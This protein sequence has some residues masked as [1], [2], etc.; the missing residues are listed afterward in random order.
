MKTMEAKMVK[1]LAHKGDP[2]VY[3][4]TPHNAVSVGMCPAFTGEIR[5]PQT[6]EYFVGNDG[7]IKCAQFNF[8]IQKFPILE[9]VTP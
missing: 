8:T 6:G 2:C 5:E 1:L 4:K 9:K 7:F 3:C